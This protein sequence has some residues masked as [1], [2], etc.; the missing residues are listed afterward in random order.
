V[1]CVGNVMIDNLFHHLD[2]CK[3]SDVLQRL[4]LVEQRL[5]AGARGTAVASIP[6][7]VV[8]T[9][10]R[11]ENVER[12][13]LIAGILQTVNGIGRA[14]PVIF[15]MPTGLRKR[16]EDW[17]LDDYFTDLTA[18][19]ESYG[20]ESPELPTGLYT[21][22]PIPYL[23]F[24]RLLSASSLVITDSGGMQEETTAMGIPCL[25][26]REDTE[27]PVTVREGTNSLVGHDRDRLRIEA[28]AALSGHGKRGRVP[29]L[30]DG[31]TAGRVVQHIAEYYRTR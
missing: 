30:W 9:L 22:P 5:A 24:L 6:K 10:S 19:L 8:V 23:D 20:G 2:R 11:P 17:G 25:T 15:P 26:L 3:T 29:K 16:L 12:R 18:R 28:Q 31:K 21:V 4:G 14:A 1:I 13:D 27:R 7:F